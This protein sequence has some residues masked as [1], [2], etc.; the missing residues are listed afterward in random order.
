MKLPNHGMGIYNGMPVRSTIDIKGKLKDKL[1][2]F[3]E[4]KFEFLES[5]D[6]PEPE[7]EFEV[8]YLNDCF[9]DMPR[10]EFGYRQNFQ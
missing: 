8:E 7:D 2:N 10:Q 5:V 3:K 6:N 4:E 9:D 1:K